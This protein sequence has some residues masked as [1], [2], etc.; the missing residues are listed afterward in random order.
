LEETAALFDGEEKH[1]DLVTLGGEAANAT[2]RMSRSIILPGSELTQE[3]M[4]DKKDKYYELKKRKVDLDCAV[5]TTDL[6][7]RAL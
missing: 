5:S 2:M 3:E 4:E 6:A 7:S 1:Q